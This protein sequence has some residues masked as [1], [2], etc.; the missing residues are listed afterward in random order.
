MKPFCVFTW[1]NKSSATPCSSAH[2]ASVRDTN[3]GPLSIRIFN[4]YPR[5]AMSLS[6]TMMTRCA[7][8]FRS[9]S[10]ASASR[11]K[12]STVL[13]IRKRRPQTS[14]SCIKPMDQLWFSGS[15]MASDAGLRTSI[16][17]H[18]AITTSRPLVSYRYLKSYKL[19][20]KC[21]TVSIVALKIS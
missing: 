4:G 16:T 1:L 8:I 14:T 11:L 13:K 15:G 18:P 21:Y 17:D 9:I 5:F 3:S 12:S 19:F 10:I 20:P 7:G 6:S 2:C